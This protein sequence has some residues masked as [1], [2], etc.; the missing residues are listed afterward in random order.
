MKNI[1]IVIFNLFL[2]C[3][4]VA[5]EFTQQKEYTIKKKKLE[6]HQT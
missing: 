1:L 5:Y 6:M 4:T 2:C 3:N